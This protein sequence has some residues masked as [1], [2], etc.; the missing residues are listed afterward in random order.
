MRVVRAVSAEPG[1]SQSNASPMPVHPSNEQMTRAHHPP[2]CHRRRRLLATS[3][4]H[5]PRVT[6][7][8]CFG[9]DNNPVRSGTFTSCQVSQSLLFPQTSRA[10]VMTHPP[11]S[12]FTSHITYTPV[13]VMTKVFFLFLFITLGR[14]SL[15]RCISSLPKASEA[16]ENVP[17]VLEASTLHLGQA[18]SPPPSSIQSRP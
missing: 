1:A 2:P 5:N 8:F 7:H 18:T 6:N 12:Q 4:R 17:L 9:Q 14:F 11:T 16:L 13:Q 15:T 10:H 3:H